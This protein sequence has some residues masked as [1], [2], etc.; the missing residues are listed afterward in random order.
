M[1]SIV[2]DSLYIVYNNFVIVVISGVISLDYSDVMGVRI[3]NDVVV[4]FFSDELQVD[5]I[6]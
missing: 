2:N 4:V 3:G 1:L 6:N 5:V